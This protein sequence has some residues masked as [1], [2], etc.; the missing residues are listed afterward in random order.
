MSETDRI[1]QFFL[2]K[3]NG[4][5]ANSIDNF[6]D[7]LVLLKDSGRKFVLLRGRDIFLLPGFRRFGENDVVDRLTHL[8][9][10]VALGD[11]N[12]REGISSF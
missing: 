10:I 9:K 7:A 3:N 8:Q 4:L 11:L 12:R 1:L 5:S 2:A 6:E